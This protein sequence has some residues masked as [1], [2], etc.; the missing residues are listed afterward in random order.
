LS[1][2]SLNQNLDFK[3][4]IALA[5]VR[6]LRLAQPGSALLSS[7]ARLDVTDFRPLPVDFFCVSS[8]VAG[9]SRAC[10]TELMA[11][12][13]REEFSPYGR[14]AAGSLQGFGNRTELETKPL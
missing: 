2:K 14:H 5:G 13:D 4:L 1:H 10:G 3:E 6:L 11:D 7:K 12:R 8:T 9:F